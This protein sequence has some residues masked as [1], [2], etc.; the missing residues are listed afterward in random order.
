MN[1]NTNA[2]IQPSFVCFPGRAIVRDVDPQVPLASRKAS[3]TSK[4][5]AGA[6]FH[7]WIARYDRRIS[8]GRSYI[9]R[10][11]AERKFSPGFGRYLITSAVCKAPIERPCSRHYGRLKNLRSFFSPTWEAPDFRS[12]GRRPAM[13]TLALSRR[14][15]R[16]NSRISHLMGER[17]RRSVKSSHILRKN[18]FFIFFYATLHVGKHR[19]V[20]TE[21]HIRIKKIFE[22]FEK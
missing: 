5:L 16:S 21:L 22:R 2:Q 10:T 9:R 15:E 1:K 14:D 18:I 8:R 13:A 7:G 12:T 3:E 4:I 6:T 17:Q 20:L 11:Y 19:F